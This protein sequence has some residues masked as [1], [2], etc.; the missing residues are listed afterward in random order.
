[1]NKYLSAIVML[2]AIKLPP[3]IKIVF[4]F[5]LSLSIMGSLCYWIADSAI[6]S[7]AT[8]KLVILWSLVFLWFLFNVFNIHSYLKRLKEY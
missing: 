5:F 4:Q 6:T 2:G 8:W 1:M 7:P 3:T